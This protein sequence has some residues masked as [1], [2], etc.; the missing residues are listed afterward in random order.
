MCTKDSDAKVMTTAAMAHGGLRS[1]V[2][3][4]TM[5][6]LLGVAEAVAEASLVVTRPSQACAGLSRRRNIYGRYTARLKQRITRMI[7]EEDIGDA[8]DDTAH[9][10]CGYACWTIRKS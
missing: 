6:L 4:P 1:M 10:S 3:S 2:R 9:A 5:V 8:H 7:T